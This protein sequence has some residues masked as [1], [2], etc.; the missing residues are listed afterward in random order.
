M[1]NETIDTLL[2]QADPSLS[3]DDVKCRLLSSTDPATDPS[4]SLAYSIFQQGA[5]MIWAPDAVY[6]SASGCAN[7]GMDIALD[8]AGE[9]HY[10]GPANVDGNGN[11]YIMDP[12]AE[13]FGTP[14]GSDG[15]LCYCGL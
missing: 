14:L 5:G 1:A 8:L 15:F 6:S 2:L 9:Q 3:P 12:D 10:G 4:D 11:Y 7:G 13:V